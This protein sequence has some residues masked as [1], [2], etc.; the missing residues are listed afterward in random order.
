MA[1]RMT[2]QKMMD[3]STQDNVGISAVRD[4]TKDCEVSLPKLVGNSY[5]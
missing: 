3:G 1:L 4:S 5:F 2:Q